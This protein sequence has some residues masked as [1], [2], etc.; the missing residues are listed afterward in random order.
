MKTTSAQAG[1]E[2][3]SAR[4]GPSCRRPSHRLRSSGCPWAGSLGSS[5]PTVLLL[6]DLGIIPEPISRP[7]GGAGVRHGHRRRST[8]GSGRN[9]GMRRCRRSMLDPCLVGRCFRRRQLHL[10]CRPP[11]W[12]NQ[13]ADHDQSQPGQEQAENPERG[14]VGKRVAGVAKSDIPNAYLQT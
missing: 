1:P 7:V 11:Q 6:L 10:A 5:K 9:D 13:Q 3:N 4:C 14:C 12:P 2:I 8:P